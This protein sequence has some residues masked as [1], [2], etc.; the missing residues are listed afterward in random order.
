VRRTLERY[1]L[2]RR[3]GVPPLDADER[4]LQGLLAIDDEAERL[5]EAERLR[6]EV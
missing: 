4:T 6:R 5:A 3:L 1:R 2:A